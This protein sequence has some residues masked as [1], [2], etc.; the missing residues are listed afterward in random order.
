MTSLREP[1]GADAARLLYADAARRLSNVARRLVPTGRDHHEGDY[2][3]EAL[4]AL[5][6][7]ERLVALAVVVERAQGTTWEKIGEADGGI[8]KQSASKKWPETS[9]TLDHLSDGFGADLLRTLSARSAAELAEALDAWYARHVEPGDN[10]G[11]ATTEDRVVSGYLLDPGPAPDLTEYSVIPDDAYE[12]WLSDHP[13]ARTARQ[14]R[15][16][17]Y[18]AEQQR[19][20]STARDWTNKMDSADLDTRYPAIPGAAES[21]RRLSEI[22]RPIADEQQLRAQL[23]SAEPDEV[24]VARYR[25]ELVTRKRV[26]GDDDYEYPPHL[27]G[28]GA[29]AYPPPTSGFNYRPPSLGDGD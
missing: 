4:L 21:M 10:F 26:A 1:A 27:I 15:M 12:W 17:D 13:W 5:R 22:M 8:T 20:A 14:Q 24:M 25:R 6:E 28:P 11:D 19:S 18:H 29:A 16:R 3:T 23:E 9:A 2:L 7:A